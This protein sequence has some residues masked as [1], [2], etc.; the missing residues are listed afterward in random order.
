MMKWTCLDL[1]TST[2]RT[3][4]GGS[5][6]CASDWKSGRGSDPAG[7]RQH[8]FVEFDHETFSTVILS[9]RL[10]QEGHLPV[11]GKRMYTSNGQVLR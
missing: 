2:V 3:G 6:R 10:I 8:S 11:S 4:L 5:I 1:R 9:L 7:V